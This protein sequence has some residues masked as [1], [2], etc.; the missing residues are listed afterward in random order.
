MG[1]RICLMMAGFVLVTSPAWAQSSATPPWDP[2]VVKQLATDAV[3]HGDAEQGLVVFASAQVA[4]VSCHRIGTHGGT[5]GPDLSRI[6]RDR[7]AEEIAESIL[8]PARKVA[9]EYETVVA[10]TADGLQVRGY[11]VE[12]EQPGQ[13]ALR[14]PATGRVTRLSED[15]VEEQLR[16]GTL[17]PNG[18]AAAI[19]RHR[20]RDLVR[21][22]TGL[23]RENSMDSGLIETVLA[24]SM[25][26]GPA[27]FPYDRKPLHPDEFPHWQ[28]Y[29]NRDRLYDW[30]TK[31]AEHFRTADVR[32]PLLA[33]FPGLDGGT[34]GH[35]GNQIESSWDN[36]DWD[37]ADHGWL[38]S[39]IFRGN[40]V[41]VT[42]GVCLRLGD[43]Q[44]VS[45]CFNT[46]T[47]TYDAVW[48]GGFVRISKVRHG[49]LNGLT[50]DGKPQQLPEQSIPGGSSHYH[51][52]YRHGDRV[53]FSYRIGETVFLDAPWAEDGRFTR[54]VAPAA[55]H[56]WKHLTEPGP[57]AWPQKIT[58]EYIRG[59]GKPFAVDTFG[60][61]K[62]NPWNMPVYC[63][64]HDFFPD[65]SALVCTIQG[66]VW[67]VTGLTTASGESAHGPVT[68]RRF[69]SG[70]H[71][72]LGLIIDSDGVFVLCRDQ[73]V[74]L[75]DRDQNGEADFY[76][77]F[78][79]E[80]ET[81]SAGHDFICGLQRDKQGRFCFA[82]GNQGLMRVSAD[83]RTAE[84]LAE[85]LRNPDGLGLY[86]DGTVTIPC[87][88]GE[89]TPATQ[90]CAVRPDR[91]VQ[92]TAGGGRIGGHQPPHFGYRGL[93]DD[94]PPDLPLVYLPRGLDNSAGGQC[95]ISSDRWGPL[96]GTMIH[97]SYG[98]GTQ[99]LLLRDEVDGQLQGGIVLLPGAFL[100]GA[101]RARFNE[102]DGQLYVSG[103]AG[104]GSYTPEPGCFHRVRYC[105]GAFALPTSFHAH[106]NGIAVGFSE[107]LDPRLAANADQHFAQCWNYR[108]SGG[109]GSLEYS[110]GH[111]GTPG[112]DFLRIRSA[113]VL[114]ND[115]VLFLEIPDLQPVN[116]L[117][118]R[119]NADNH[120]GSDLFLTIH[121]L[122]KPF[123]DFDGYAAEGKSVAPHPILADV[124]LMNER[125]PNPFQEQIPSARLITLETATNLSF[126][127]R[128]FTASAGEPIRFTLKNP[129]VVPHNWALLK[130]G[131]LKDVGQL[132]NQLVADPAAFARH[133][134]PRTDDVLVYTDVVSPK[135]EFTIFFHAPSK[136]GQ[137]PYLCTFPGHWMVMN[138]VM[139]VE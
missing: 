55:E 20:Q 8:W 102:V 56:P 108:F 86:P 18:L 48:T 3:A 51:G 60:L 66:D 42:R 96:R 44:E 10:L 135:T 100:S 21:F 136:P 89:W 107:S 97:T 12:A 106:E 133:Y 125:L 120:R 9:P 81:S 94:R 111:S 122:D 30:Y 27:T 47:L 87:S 138:G 16:A 26:H 132:A 63:G 13:I 117:H 139:I 95:W 113:H 32:P 14:D 29:V 4:C 109:Y 49:V 15:D 19:T 25:T 40:H 1:I 31:Q 69:A 71:H 128:Q 34:L 124:I 104:W 58:T 76:E 22:L 54:V 85:G 110:P 35:W 38:L 73:I 84:V 131:T 74:R 82:S 61:P 90:I 99:F 134:I 11:L 28:H 77:C 43:D 137:Y 91:P 70:L 129:D 126:A 53:V 68:W 80:F 79:K 105:G 75:H 57:S 39:G 7:T 17:M 119:L 123:E 33:P 24:H 83:G 67:H 72:A 23:G 64:G 88:E 121:A 6:G 115:R 46:D 103:M 93:K 130:P 2:D 59:D 52:F 65:G 112:H 78:S 116:Q 127:T 41:Q 36:S 92:T 5:V 50:M 98:T 118:L 62:E 114:E 37:R 101:H 45:A